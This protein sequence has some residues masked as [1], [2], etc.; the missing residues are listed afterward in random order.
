M[1]NSKGLQ[2]IGKLILKNVRRTYNAFNTPS[3]DAIYFMTLDNVDEEGFLTSTKI[4]QAY[5]CAS[6]KE[7]Y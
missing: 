1:F 2:E 4:M 6:F 7:F 3:I 5:G